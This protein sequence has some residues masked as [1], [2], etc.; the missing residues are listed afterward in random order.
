MA[1]AGRIIRNPTD[2]LNYV[3]V[4]KGKFHS[5]ERRL[6]AHDVSKHI[7][8]PFRYPALPRHIRPVDDE[9]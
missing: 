9:R 8:R 4:Q 1:A 6:G 2:N 5:K 7:I 3:Q